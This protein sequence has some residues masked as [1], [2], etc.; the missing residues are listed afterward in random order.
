MISFLVVGE[1]DMINSI[2]INKIK[3]IDYLK[4]QLNLI[5]NKPSIFVAPNGFG[6][7]SITAAF[8]S[9]SSNKLIIT[10]DNLHNSKENSDSYIKI[11]DVREKN[12]N[13]L[14][15]DLK[16]NSIS[17]KYK[18]KVINNKV[19]SDA[20]MLNINGF[21]IPKSDLIVKDI[22]LTNFIPEKKYFNYFVTKYRSEYKINKY[23]F[24]NLDELFNSQNFIIRL[25]NV[26]KNLDNI[27]KKKRINETISE[28]EAQFQ[29]KTIKQ[30]DFFNA[31]DKNELIDKILDDSDVRV[32]CDDLDKILNIKNKVKKTIFVIQLIKVY[33]D[34]K[35]EFVKIYKRAVYEKRKKSLEDL[36]KAI[37]KKKRIVTISEQKGKL[38]VKFIRA[39]M[40]SNGETDLLCFLVML[41]KIKYEEINKDL[42]L[43]IDE[44]FDYL[45]DANI[46]V[47]QK[48]ISSFIKSFTE[49]DK[50]I[51]P[52]IM[53]HLD[54]NVFK[55]YYFSKMKVYYLNDINLTI[56]DEV[57]KIITDRKNITDS[58]N[59][60]YIGKYYLHYNNETRDLS[61]IFSDKGLS[62]KYDSSEK[63]YRL[64][65]DEMKK[66]I[67]NLPCDY[68]LVLCALRINIEK[69]IYECIDDGYKASFIE[70]KMTVNKIAF[71]E[72]IG[73]RI[74][75]NFQLLS[76]LYNDFMH[77][78]KSADPQN[79]KVLFLAS[80]LD[81]IFIKSIIRSTMKEIGF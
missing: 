76:V 52:I 27:L 51:F 67:D 13:E 7:S 72:Q 63:F 50:N 32:I 18:V 36:I 30:T 81:N 35:T 19:T 40:I 71:A 17:S 25:G 21:N 15:A 75:E 48:Y 65:N 29:T 49:S 2:E 74:P 66:Y 14:I 80:K 3:C 4:L 73:I 26:K 70:E 5:P 54:P 20:K 58:S 42:I 12:E 77:L 22:T 6:K 8:D 47:V 53:T 56:D 34:N 45:D 31:F 16:T 11:C 46:I 43:V 78:D 39:N 55:N 57:R 68:L 64:S 10:R 24:S 60:D 38:I 28:L 44:V 79:K 61:T 41:E 69:Y 59:F 23:I 37:D 33:N 62:N 1:A 9:I